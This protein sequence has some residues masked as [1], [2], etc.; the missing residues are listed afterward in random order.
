MV[1]GTTSR[2]ICH[3]LLGVLEAL[4]LEVSA[5]SQQSKTF[6][7]L[8]ASPLRYGNIVRVQYRRLE[9]SPIGFPLAR[10]ISHSIPL[11][12]GAVSHYSCSNCL[13]RV[14]VEVTVMESAV[15]RSFGAAA[16]CSLALRRDVRL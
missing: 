5:T 16:S 15:E 4:S 12:D 9:F 10:P 13:V 14:K 3:L 6:T 8:T 2:G 1:G 11:M 7:S